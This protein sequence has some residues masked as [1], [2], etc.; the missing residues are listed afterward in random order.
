MNRFASPFVK[1]AFEGPDIHEEV[2]YDLCRVCIAIFM[3]LV[4][5]PLPISHTVKSET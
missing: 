4:P 5:R 1:V 3:F 2:L